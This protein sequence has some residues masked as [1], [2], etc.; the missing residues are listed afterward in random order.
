M[1]SRPLSALGPGWP[2]PVRPDRGVTSGSGES[3]TLAGL[4]ELPDDATLRGNGK[5]A[6]VVTLWRRDSTAVS[7]RCH[8]APNAEA[9]EGRA[10]LDCGRAD[11]FGGSWRVVPNDSPSRGAE[12]MPTVPA[13]GR[14]PRVGVM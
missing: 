3:D 11:I 14:R 2:V 9:L 4:E 6:S 13:E 1:P 8:L 10:A 7:C 12:A 5:V